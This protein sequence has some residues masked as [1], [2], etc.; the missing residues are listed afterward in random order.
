MLITSP[1]IALSA[2]VFTV[3]AVA[4][5]ANAAAGPPTNIAPTWAPISKKIIKSLVFI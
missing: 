4:L 2:P 3:S 5:T 1:L